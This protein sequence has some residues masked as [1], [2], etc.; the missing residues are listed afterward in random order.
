MTAHEVLHKHFSETGERKSFI[1]RSEVVGWTQGPHGSSRP[2][3]GVVVGRE[4][5]GIT[6]NE[7]KL[8]IQVQTYVKVTGNEFPLSLL[9][10]AKPH[11]GL[12]GY[13]F[14]ITEDVSPEH[15][16]GLDYTQIDPVALP[17][18]AAQM[19]IP[20]IPTFLT[21]REGSLSMPIPHT[22]PLPLPA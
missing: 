8:T 3:T 12:S 7:E 5:R 15:A 1:P 6:S 16:F 9:K 17:A 21:A 20:L 11:S 22:A 13:E 10:G 4:M 19:L 18:E 2:V 14:E